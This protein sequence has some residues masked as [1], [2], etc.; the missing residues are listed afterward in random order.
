MRTHTLRSC[1]THSGDAGKEKRQ[2]SS[3]RE[4]DPRWSFQWLQSLKLSIFLTFFTR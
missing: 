1:L 2:A 4:F 3:L